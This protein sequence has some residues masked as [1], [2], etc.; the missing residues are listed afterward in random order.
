M[1][2][3][4]PTSQVMF[5]FPSWTSCG[6]FSSLNKWESTNDKEIFSDVLGEHIER[7]KASVQYRCPDQTILEHGRLD[8]KQQIDK[9][10]EKKVMTTA[11]YDPQQIISRIFWDLNNMAHI[12]LSQNSKN[13]MEQLHIY[14]LKWIHYI[15]KLINS[16]KLFNVINRYEKYILLYSCYIQW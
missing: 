13:W 5:Q 10:I 16:T 12:G 7:S 8:M 11:T 15:T 2:I 4:W 3:V 14:I 9:L 6:E 1:L